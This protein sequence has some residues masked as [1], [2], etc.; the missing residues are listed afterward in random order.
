MPINLWVRET[1]NVSSNY[2]TSC[3]TQV[4]WCEGSML[5][6]TTCLIYFSLRRL[7]SWKCVTVFCYYLKS[8]SNCT[9]NGAELFHTKWAICEAAVRSFLYLNYIFCRWQGGKCGNTAHHIQNFFLI[10]SGIRIISVVVYFCLN[11]KTGKSKRRHSRWRYNQ[12][13]TATGWYCTF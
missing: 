4:L 1:W 13:Q 7:S 9:V 10:I 5:F 6:I 3:S 2:Q 12:I 8:S 11:G